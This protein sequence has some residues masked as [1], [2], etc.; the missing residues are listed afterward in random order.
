MSAMLA[1]PILVMLTFAFKAWYSSINRNKQ[2]PVKNIF[3][4]LIVFLAVFYFIGFAIY[5]GGLMVIDEASLD[6]PPE[7]WKQVMMFAQLGLGPLTALLVFIDLEK[8][9][10]HYSVEK[11]YYSKEHLAC[12]EELSHLIARRQDNDISLASL[13]GFEKAYD[14]VKNSFISSF[15]NRQRSYKIE[16]ESS[17]LSA[18][19]KFITSRHEVVKPALQIIGGRS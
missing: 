3:F 6:L 13:E 19:S 1:T 17:I 2:R 8:R 14:K 15:L 10:H 7:V 11:I 12:D 9:A 4:S 16:Y 5:Y 18:K